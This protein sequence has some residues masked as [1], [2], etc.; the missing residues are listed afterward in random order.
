[1]ATQ[2]STPGT[3]D[4]GED[5]LKQAEALLKQQ[6]F[7]AAAAVLEP[8]C[9]RDP[10]HRKALFLLAVSRR[11]AR[12]FDEAMDVL[13]RLLRVAPDYGRAWQEIGH[14]HR[15]RNRPRDAAEAYERAV[16]LN[17]GLAASWRFLA[18]A[19]RHL[20]EAE[21]ARVAQANFDRLDRLPKELVA[22]TSMMHEGQLYK[23]EQLCRHFLQNNPHHL[24]AMRLLAAIGMQ[25][26]IYDDAEFLLESALEMDPDFD[27]ARADYVKV[28]QRRQKFERAFEEAQKLR[29]RMPGNI[30]AELA[31]A[32]QASA[33]GRYEEALAVLDPLLDRVPNPANVQMLRG[34]ALKTIGEHDRAVHAYREASRERPQLGDAW[35][36]L[37]N[38]KTF[39]FDDAEM[40]RMEALVDQGGLSRVDEYHLCFALGKAWEDRG[41][42]ERS[43]AYYARGNGLK[44]DEL[45]YSADRMQADFDR[46]KAFFTPERVRQF[47]GLGA[48]DDDPIFIV[49][50]PRAGSTLVEQ[51]LASH[52]RVDGTL[53]LPNILATVH[54][55]NGRLRRGEAPRYPGVL[56][57]L[58]PER[59]EEMGRA[60]IDETRVHRQGAPLFTDKMPNNFRHIGLILSILPNARIIDARR[61]P[62]ACCFSGYKQLFAEGQEFTYSLDDIGRYYA[63]YVDLMDHWKRLYPDS[64]LQVDYE[65]VVD[66][67]DGQVRRMLDFLGL[68]FEPDCVEFHRTRRSVRTA[69]SEQVR[70]PIYRSGVEQWRHF[71]PWLDDLKRAL[72]PE[73]VPEEE[74]K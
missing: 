13:Q 2:A 57:E 15:D 8:L 69:S 65:D 18:A 6:R 12:R 64:I 66:D 32:N 71:E 67:L 54:K 47:A 51:I 40:E 58:P 73:R 34:H 60:Y 19:R 39:R 21:S 14:N 36:S 62:M 37:A 72:G 29:E 38:M 7:D 68:P 49:G 63:G 53:E 45:R 23:A 50:L 16:E 9:E 28:L 5:E 30:S 61:A 10:E 70:R 55:L 46:Q 20:G 74:C 27:L 56:A 3:Q 22:V 59:F 42:Y 35:W 33:V 11:A 48:D 44:K 25:L 26:N 24:E 52:S 17:P 41:D 43:F 31:Y 4:S 1:M